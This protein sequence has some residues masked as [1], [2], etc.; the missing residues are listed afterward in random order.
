M[1]KRF[2]RQQLFGDL[3]LSVNA[4]VTAAGNSQATGTALT[5]TVNVVT[6]GT[7]TSADGVV[8]PPAE[9]GKV[10]VIMA[11]YGAALAVWPA[12]GDAINDVAA[13]GE[14]SQADNTVAIYIAKDGTTWY[15]L[16]A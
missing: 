3:L 9:A 8:L 5:K 4:A 7:A 16:E 6:A 10:C 2:D 12:S 15:K 14:A 1:T 13:D 11:E